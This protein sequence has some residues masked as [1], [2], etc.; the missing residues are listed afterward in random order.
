MDRVGRHHGQPPSGLSLKRLAGSPDA[1][2]KNSKPD[3]AQAPLG[4]VPQLVRT[5][6]ELIPPD[7]ADKLVTQPNFVPLD[8]YYLRYVY[9]LKKLSD[10][11]RDSGPTDPLCNRGLVLKRKRRAKTRLNRWPCRSSCSTGSCAMFRLNRWNYRCSSSSAHIAAGD[12]VSRRGVPSNSVFNF[13][14]RYRRWTAA[15]HSVCKL[16]SPSFAEELHVGH[17]HIHRRVTT[18]VTGV[19][20]GGEIYLFDCSLG[21]PVLVLNSRALPLLPRRA[22]MPVYCGD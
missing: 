9:L 16:M 22:A 17:D 13:V 11:V 21:V 3:A 18:V 6:S 15:K 8:V 2:S 5:V 12:E 10:W 14:P 19:L 1:T 7:E 20:I 4:Q